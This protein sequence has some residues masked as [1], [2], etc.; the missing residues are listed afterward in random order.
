MTALVPN[1]IEI[2]GHRSVPALQMFTVSV[3]RKEKL[4]RSDSIF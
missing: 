4:E 1:S 2:L 3:G